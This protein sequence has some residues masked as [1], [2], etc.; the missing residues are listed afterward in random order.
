VAVGAVAS[1]RAMRTMRRSDGG[2]TRAASSN[3]GMVR[4]VGDSGGSGKR[5]R[6]SRGED[7]R[8][9]HGGRW[10]DGCSRAQWWSAAVLT[11]LALSGVAELPDSVRKGGGRRP[12]YVGG[13]RGPTHGASG[14]PGDRHGGSGRP[15]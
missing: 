3:A 12:P 10:V 11:D 9:W 4:A 13:A 6:T 14:G 1:T 8:G 2:T 15:A 7:R 5:R